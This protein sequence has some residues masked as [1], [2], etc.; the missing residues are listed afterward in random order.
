[1]RLISLSAPLAAVMLTAACAPASVAP[2]TTDGI[3]VLD[4]LVGAATTWP[5]YGDQQQHQIVDSSQKR[6]CWTKYGEAYSFECWR[7]DDQYV[8]HLI[9][10][11]SS[12]VGVVYRFTDGRWLP[13]VLPRSAWTLDLPDNRIESISQQ[14]K[15]SARR[16]PYRV[17]AWLEPSSDAGGDL[18]VR[19]VLRLEY[20]P[21]DPNNSA[22]GQAERFSFAE[23][24]G[25]F[26]WTNVEGFNISFN[27]IGGLTVMPR[28]MC[29]ESVQ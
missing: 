17:S 22:V 16:F 5:R 3:D 10:Q 4:Y 18:G 11:Q 27:R 20:Q 28:W 7:W 9:D 1:M 23:G 8:Y 12:T 13:R 24:A 29:P 6:V 14:C 15:V 21:Y 19:N 25:W 2:S 26:R